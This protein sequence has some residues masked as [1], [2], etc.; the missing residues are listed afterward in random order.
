MARKP[1]EISENGTYHVIMRGVAKNNVFTC[2][3][4]REKFKEVMFRYC[5][6]LKIG[7][8]SY[9][10]MDN[11]IH[12]EVQEMGENNS[13][14][15]VRKIC[16][17]YVQ[18]YF[19]K[20]YDRSGALFQHRYKSRAIESKQDVI[21]VSKYIHQ[22]ALVQGISE[23][24]KYTSYSEILDAYDKKCPIK[25]IFAA[26]IERMM[27]KRHFKDMVKKCDK[28]TLMQEDYTLNDDQVRGYLCRALNIESV[29]FLH[30]ADRIR[31]NLA[32]KTLA[33]N[34]IT[35]K[36]LSRITSLTKP[37]LRQICFC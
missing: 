26:P 3:D 35:L 20:K 12:M 19:N 7:L 32:L 23:P 5:E 13:S 36:R 34:G 31:R 27:N 24:F 37:E 15:L 33:E 17:S 21:N 28:V 4:D 22:N 9:I 25:A 1:R 6:E 16:I 18:H 14:L 11:H 29:G 2:D 30:K 8:I 10:L